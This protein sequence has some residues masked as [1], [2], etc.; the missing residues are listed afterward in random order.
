MQEYECTAAKTHKRFGLLSIMLYSF[1]V[2]DPDY[3]HGGIAL[4]KRTLHF[5]LI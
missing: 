5:E 4:K 2:K 1:N 3:Y